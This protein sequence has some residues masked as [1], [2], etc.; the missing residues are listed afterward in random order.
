MCGIVGAV[1]ERN[2]T[3]ILLE[4]LRRLEYRGYDSAG[5]AVLDEGDCI[6]R[7]RR[8]GKVKELSDALEE[9]AIRGSMG[10][11]H[12]RWATHGEPSEQNAHPHVCNESVVIV[13]NGIIENHSELREQQSSA[14]FNFTSQTDTEVAVHQIEHYLKSQGDL[15]MAV[16]SAVAD[17]EGAYALGV[18]SNTDRGRLIATRRGSPLVI[19]VGIGEYFIASD[20]AAL[21]PVTR[22]FIYL[23]EGDIADIRTDALIIYNDAGE[24]VEREIKESELSADSTA[25]GEYRHY[26]L[27]EIHE[28]PSCL[29]DILEGRVVDGQLL[30]STFGVGAEKILDRV[31]AVQIIACGT[32]YHAGLVA[33]YWLEAIAGVP[34]RVEV[35]SEY[36]YRKT[37]L[38][39][40]TLVVTISQSGETADTLAAL[41]AIKETTDMTLSVCNVPESSLVRESEL[42]LMTRAGPEIGVASTKA[43][44]TQLV[45]LLMLVVALGKRRELSAD[46]I[47]DLFYQAQALPALID[48]V[49]NDKQAIDQWAED[50]TDLHNAI[51]IGRGTLY[52][53]ALEGALKLKEISYIHADAYPAGELKHGP[54]ALIDHDLPTIAIASI[55]GFEGKIKSNIQEILARGGSVYLFADERM[56]VSDLGEHCK[57]MKIPAVEAELAPVLFSVPLQ[58]FSYF[59]AVRKGTDVDQPRNLAKSVTVE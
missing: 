26:M 4:G 24:V 46:K 12:T 17:F 19:G 52:P 1:A 40:D 22:R 31:K 32:S 44:T 36:R 23:D 37:V 49:L 56:D 29:L 45:A 2:V 34:C 27:K 8:V 3:P 33:R 10:V 51:F 18:M 59:V 11:A 28:Q 16:R 39:D 42:K 21:L 5:I 15:L 43:F 54:I 9:N 7:V 25:K 41:R 30:D 53:I 20:A 6:S 35:A 48:Q 38:A 13:H 55:D 57:V 50:F 58:L 47:K 14:G